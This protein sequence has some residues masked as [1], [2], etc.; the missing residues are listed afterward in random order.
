MWDFL[1]FVGG[2]FEFSDVFIVRWQTLVLMLLGAGLAYL[3]FG[4]AGALIACVGI[5]LIAVIERGVNREKRK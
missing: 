4:A 5:Y 1:D 2:I 3:I